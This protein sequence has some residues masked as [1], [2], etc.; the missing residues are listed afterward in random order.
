MQEL[1]KF[2]I[3]KPE[4]L[5]IIAKIEVTSSG[6]AVPNAITVAP[7]ISSLSPKITEILLELSTTK[8]PP[9]FSRTLPKITKNID[10]I[11][12]IYNK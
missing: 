10:W 11:W 3:A 12:K 9:N 5:L 8:S 4:F 7:M 1:T 6:R 2:P